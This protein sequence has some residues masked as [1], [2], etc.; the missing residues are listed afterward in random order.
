[1]A[2]ERD[3]SNLVL[4]FS[5]VFPTLVTLAYFVLL[6]GWPAK[7]QLTTY[8]VGKVAQFVFPVVYLV[9]ILHHRL[10]LPQPA[11]RGIWFGLGFGVLVALLMLGLFYGWFKPQGLFDQP[12]EKI[13]DKVAGW[14][15]TAAW[16]FALLGLFYALAHSFLEEYYWRWFVFDQLDRK[17]SLSSAVAISSLGFMAHHVILMATFFGWSSPLTYLFS[18]GVAIGGVVWA[19]IYQASGS[20]LGPWIS[21]LI[22]DAVIFVIGFDLV[23]ERFGW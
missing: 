1:M 7:F 22:V 21:H 6:D 23:R 18:I 2:D 13:Y 9:F 20:L 10:T 5:L 3:A 4:I 15:L 12:R 11:A 8:T 17:V 19:L 14:G 16:Q